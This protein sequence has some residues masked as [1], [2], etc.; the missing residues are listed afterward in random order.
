M[1]KL[2][3]LE[4]RD[5]WKRQGRGFDVVTKHEL[6]FEKQIATCMD[7]GC[8][9]DVVVM[10]KPSGTNQGLGTLIGEDGSREY[11]ELSEKGKEELKELENELDL[12]GISDT[13]TASVHPITGYAIETFKQYFH[14]MGEFEDFLFKYLN[15]DK[16]QFFKRMEKLFDKN[17]ICN[18]CPED[19]DCW[20]RFKKNELGR[21]R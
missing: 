18:H 19:C 3:D 10:G 14:T 9:Q 16:I 5:C 7:C 20:E 21:R 12:S 8:V 6:N 17:M 2:A 13:I 4:C 15:D 1:V 11:L